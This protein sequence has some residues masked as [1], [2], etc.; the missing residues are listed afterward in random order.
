LYTKE[1]LGA[2]KKEPNIYEFISFFPD[3]GKFRVEIPG[4]RYRPIFDTLSEA[5]AARERMLASPHFPQTQRYEPRRE[6]A[7]Y[8]DPNLETRNHEA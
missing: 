8:C 2:V 7:M 3:S 4:A 1:E 5:M 6:F